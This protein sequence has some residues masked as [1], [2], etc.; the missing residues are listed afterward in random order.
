M[1]SRFEVL[2]GDQRRAG[3]PICLSLMRLLGVGTLR[4]SFHNPQCEASW[5]AQ[6]QHRSCTN[7]HTMQLGVRL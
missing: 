2:F 1:T 5:A 7:L 3:L 6:L 4:R